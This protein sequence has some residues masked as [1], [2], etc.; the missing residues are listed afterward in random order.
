MEKLLYKFIDEGKQE[1]EEISAFI[2]EFKTT[3]ELLFKEKNKSLSELRF[4]VYGLYSKEEVTETMEEYMSKTRANYGSGIA[5]PKIDDKDHFELKGQFLKELCDN[6]FSGLD[7]EDA[8]EHIEKVLEIF[9]LFHIHNITQ[10]QVILRVFP[11]S[12]TGATSRWL[13]NKPSSSIK[14]LEDLKVKFL[15]KYCP[16]ARTAKKIEEINNFQQEPDETQCRLDYATH[17]CEETNL[18]LNWEKC[19]FMVK[20]G[21]I[22][23]HKISRAGIEVDRAKINNVPFELMYDASDFAIG[24]ILGQRIDGKFKLI[25]YAS[26]TLNN[27]QEHYTTT[28][29]ELLAVVFSFDKFRPY[30]ILSKTIVYT[31]HSAL[32]YLFSKQDAKPRLI[33]GVLLL[34]GFDIKIKDKKGVENLVADHLSRLENPYFRVFIEEEIIDEF[35]DKHLMMLKA[36]P[37][38]DEP[39]LCPD[40][41]MRR[42]VVGSEI[43]EILALYHSGPTGG[44]HSASVTKRKV[45]E[46]GFFWPSIFKDARDYVMRCDACQRSGN[47]SSR[48]E[49]PQTIF[50]SV[51]YKPKDW[52]EKLNDA[53]WAFRTVYKTLTGCTPCNMDL[54]AA[55]KNRFMD[56]NELM[57]LRDGAYKNTR[58]YKEKTKKWHDSK[59]R[60]DKDFKVGD[61]VLLFNSRLRMHPGKLKSKWLKKYYDGH[62]NT[63]DKE[64][65][66]FNEGLRPS[67]STSGVSK[68]NFE[69]YVN[70]NDAVMQNMQ[71]QMTNI[72]DLLTKMVNSNQ[73]STSS[74]GSLPS[75]TVANPKVGDTKKFSYNAIESVN[76][77]DFIDIT[78]E[79]YSQ[80]VL[81]F[82]EVLA[83]GNS[84]PSFE[85]I[86]DTTS[87]TLTPFEGSDFILEE[88]EAELSDTS[89]KSGID[90]AECDLEKDILL[91][92]AILNSEPLPPLPNH[93]NY[94]PEVRKELKVCEA[95]TDETSI[96]EPPER[97]Q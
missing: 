78:C 64:V 60:G 6:T 90:D 43:L 51:G 10:D 21:I 88:I 14:T 95:K 83:N 16:P 72:T 65:I 19:H 52:S 12:L 59:L 50:W 63:E 5:R 82:S 15:S 30:L 38:D 35:P 68:T 25:Y 48:S 96:D 92:E 47:I 84:I 17:L 23:G 97:S 73:A 11:M 70:A 2:R 79:E 40:K 42:C 13:R 56:L 24:S 93:A 45:Y 41:I 87:P 37:N 80:E 33:R 46:S 18:V 76:K 34:Q 32:K 85:P 91:L 31:N 55:P 44:H 89:Y 62:I 20:E 54:V 66:E 22:L 53:L 57:E 29:K 69:S 75:N 77:V 9:D 74:S 58:I 8:N 81:G 3:N 4:E 1:H 86:V 28:E 7:H 94:F 27:A 71:N 26:K 61:K 36:K 67:S 39:W 49:M